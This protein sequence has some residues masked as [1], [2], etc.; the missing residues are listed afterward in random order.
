MEEP[1]LGTDPVNGRM[2][3]PDVE[4]MKLQLLLSLKGS[5]PPHIQTT[6][7]HAVRNKEAG[8]TALAE[9]LVELQ[10][11]GDDL[12]KNILSHQERIKELTGESSKLRMKVEQL[13]DA[14]SILIAYR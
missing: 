14:I 1:A 13:V 7:V 2:E 5:L 3:P 9:A 11:F 12:D 10:S 8:V 4:E 6:Y